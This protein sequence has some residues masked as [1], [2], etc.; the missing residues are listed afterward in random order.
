MFHVEHLRGN[1]R[2]RQSRVLDVSRETHSLRRGCQMFH[3]ERLY[4]EREYQR[5]P[6]VA[7]FYAPS[8]NA[9]TGDFSLRHDWTARSA[10]ELPMTTRRRCRALAA[11]LQSMNAVASPAK[12]S[13]AWMHRDEGSP[14]RIN[15]EA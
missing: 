11:G 3:V 14:P 7:M 8:R 1:R 6:N 4:G 10:F 15:Y 5:G 2:L 13:H 9:V 12:K